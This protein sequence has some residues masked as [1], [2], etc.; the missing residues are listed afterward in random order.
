MP[1]RFKIAWI[2]T[3]TGGV[4]PDKNP[5][6]QTAIEIFINEEM[7]KSEIFYSAPFEG[8]IVEDEALE[9]N[10]FTRE[11]INKFPSPM[12]THIKIVKLLEK[13]VNRYNPLDKFIFAGYGA[14]FDSDFMRAFFVKNG[15]NYFGS[16]F[17]SLPMDV[18]SFVAE[19]LLLG[20][21]KPMKNF[22]LGTVCEQMGIDLGEKAHDAME[23][24]RATRELY[25][26][27]KECYFE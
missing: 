23:D 9:K 14:R 2:D 24:I 18:M 4:N 13:Y 21:V 19:G 1:Q 20:T 27:L 25:E 16:Y 6:L 3:E 10:G 8:D 7:I 22:Q 17:Y 15:D 26:K 12:I 11:Q 5:L